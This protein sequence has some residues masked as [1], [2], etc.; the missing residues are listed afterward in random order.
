ML[1][2]RGLRGWRAKNWNRAWSKSTVMA[3]RSQKALSSDVLGHVLSYLSHEEVWES[4][5]PNKSWLEPR[6]RMLRGKLRAVD[7]VVGFGYDG[8]IVAALDGGFM[9]ADYGDVLKAFSRDGTLLREFCTTP[10]SDPDDSR[11]T[12][13]VIST[14]IAAALLGDGT[15]WI[16][17][18]D[19]ERVAKFDLNTNACLMQ[20]AQ[21]EEGG[22]TYRPQDLALVG[23]KLLVL[24]LSE[25]YI[26]EAALSGEVGG[27]SVYDA[28][29]GTY[30][31]RFAH[32]DAANELYMRRPTSFAVSGALC[33]VADWRTHHVKVFNHETGEFIRAFGASAPGLA[34]SGYEYSES[35]AYDD[36]DLPQLPPGEFLC[37]YGVAVAHGRLYV[38]EERGRRIQVLGLPDGA[39]LQVI[40]SPDGGCLGRMCINGGG[41]LWC[42][43]PKMGQTHIHIFA[44]YFPDPAVAEAEHR[45]RALTRADWAIGDCVLATTAYEPGTAEFATAV[46]A[47]RDF[48]RTL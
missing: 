45:A 2:E 28:R 30:R 41:L 47:T 27:I 14:P 35:A 31:Y 1:N 6:A 3:D 24:N 43:G 46:A 20:L 26:S 4:G 9:V 22:F 13:P 42:Y 32:K 48:M 12:A 23:D 39:P 25:T 15:A 38:S 44:P 7:H 34:E 21:F 18:S 8:G 5:A 19:D 16:I 11:R 29:V 36:P 33:Y 37:P 40:K 10:V 17:E